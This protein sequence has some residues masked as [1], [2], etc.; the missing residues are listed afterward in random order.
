MSELAGVAQRLAE[1][2]PLRP[3]PEA[4]AVAPEPARVAPKAAQPNPKKEPLLSTGLP[5]S[6]GKM[7]GVLATGM[8]LTWP[9]V[10]TLAGLKARGGHFNAGRK[11]L[12]DGGLV[13]EDGEAV[14]ISEPGTATVGGA[15][16]CPTTPTELLAFWSAVLPSTPRRIVDQLCR[17]DGRWVA[18][19]RLAEFLGLQPRGGHWN[20]AIAI[21]RQ[22]KLI[23][24]NGDRLRAAADLCSRTV[25][26]R[27]ARQ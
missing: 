12:R 20:A 25:V 10:A 26:A 5:S 3:A 7:L 21:L 17:Q 19:D 24:A 18:K 23:E 14:A 11:A 27:E 13:V 8:R 4:A 9:Q 15:R 1:E 16:P 6:A 22:N 2:A